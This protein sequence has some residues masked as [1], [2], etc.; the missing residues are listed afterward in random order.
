MREVEVRPESRAQMKVEAGI[1]ASLEALM[2]QVGLSG[3]NA[4]ANRMA[5][6]DSF[7]S[8]D[9]FDADMMNAPVFGALGGLQPPDN[10]GR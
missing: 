6:D 10:G 2:R 5:M 9:S 8:E 1:E 7:N 3:D 4:G